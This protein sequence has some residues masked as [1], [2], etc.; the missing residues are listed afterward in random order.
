MGRRRQGKC[1]LHNF[2][3]PSFCVFR[4]NLKYQKMK[5]EKDQNNR[6]DR[7]RKGKGQKNNILPMLVCAVRHAQKGGNDEQI[8]QGRYYPSCGGRGCGIYPSSVYRYFWH[9]EKCGDYI[10]PA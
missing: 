6:A 1:R 5:N 7:K 4:K 8:Q 9:V 3:A 2:P 10:Q